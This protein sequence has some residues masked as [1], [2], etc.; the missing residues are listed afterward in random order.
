MMLVSFEVHAA[1]GEGNA[2][3]FQAEAL[4]IGGFAREFDFSAGAE[5]PLPGHYTSRRTQEPG[6]QAMMQWISSGGGNLAVGGYFALWNAADEIQ[7]ASIALFGRSHRFADDSPFEL[8][9]YHMYR[10]TRGWRRS[11][12]G[13]LA[14][15]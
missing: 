2:F 14:V 4:F 10:I 9:A 15:M 13:G 5:D 1:A 12:G 7:N 8:G 3:D 11:G 6:Y